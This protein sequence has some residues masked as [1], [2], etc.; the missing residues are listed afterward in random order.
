MNINPT[1]H[2]SQ[3]FWNFYLPQPPLRLPTQSSSF[4]IFYRS[5]YKAYWNPSEIWNQTRLSDTHLVWELLSGIKSVHL[6]GK[7]I[8]KLFYTSRNMFTY[9][10]TTLHANDTLQSR[11]DLHAETN[12]SNKFKKQKIHCKENKLNQNMNKR[13][14]AVAM[15]KK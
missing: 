9:I 2:H 4:E 13:I 5:I 15:T 7:G 10:I 1:Y 3:H 6:F 12:N 14:R 8:K 11:Y